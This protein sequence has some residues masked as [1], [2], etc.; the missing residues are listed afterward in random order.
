M[1]IEKSDNEKLIIKMLNT[2]IVIVHSINTTFIL[3]WSRRL[4]TLAP[5]NS[6]F[7]LLGDFNLSDSITW[8]VDSDGICRPQNVRGVKKLMAHA[9]LELPKFNFFRVSF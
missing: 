2:S 1:L 3:R 6:E 8:N 5:Q 4:F 9:L 7:L